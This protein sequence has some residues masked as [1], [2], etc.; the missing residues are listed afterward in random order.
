MTHD[1]KMNK[2][3]ATEENEP[4][5]YKEAKMPKS[6]KE[7]MVEDIEGT[8]TVRYLFVESHAELLSAK[9][10]E[11]KVL[12]EDHEDE[13]EDEEKEVIKENVKIIV[14]EDEEFC[15]L[16]YFYFY[17]KGEGIK[18][19]HQNHA[20]A[21]DQFLNEETDWFMAHLMEQVKKAQ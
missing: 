1:L 18:L 16:L 12:K 5:T 20:E 6:L 14:E 21:V 19:A 2:R 9:L 8:N 4:A 15:A 17:N 10:V 3:S 13:D 7:L 11:Y